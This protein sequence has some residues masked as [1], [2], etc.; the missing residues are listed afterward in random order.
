MTVSSPEDG[1]MKTRI[2]N[3]FYSGSSGAG[4][5]EG[6]DLSSSDSGSSREEDDYWRWPDEYFL[7]DYVR[8]NR[9]DDFYK[10][11]GDPL[12]PSLLPLKRRDVIGFMFASIGVTLGSSGGIGGT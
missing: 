5:L 11:I 4:N 1:S 10:Y 3:Y 6:R 2:L 7:D 9:D 12:P 8:R